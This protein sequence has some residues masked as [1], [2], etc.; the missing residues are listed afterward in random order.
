M[1]LWPR[2]CPWLAS[3]RGRAWTL[4]GIFGLGIALQLTTLFVVIEPDTL[5]WPDPKCHHA[6][7]ERLAAGQPFSDAET[8]LNL[9]YSP[10]Y[11]F[12]LSLMMRLVGPRVV[13]LRLFHIALFPVF[14]FCL[15]LLG[16]LWR[17]PRAGLVLAFTAAIY[18]PFLYIPLSLYP[19]ALLIYVYGAIGLTMY[20]LWRRMHLPGLA[21]LGAL[22]A[23]AVMVRPTSVVWIPVAVG[24]LLWR[25]GLRARRALA[26]AAILFLIPAAATLGW[27]ARNQAAHDQFTFSIT[28]AGTLL[29]TFNENQFG[30]AKLSTPP[31]R[32]LKR[33]RE[34]PSE[35]ERERIMA[36]EALRFVRE[37]PV[38]AAR[39]VALQC[40][41]TWH[42][43][44]QTHLK[45]GLATL[46]YKIPMAVPYLLLLTLGIIGIVI[47]RKDSLVRALVV[48]MVLNTLIN[49][50]FSVSV[51]YRV[52]TDFGF[53]L[54]A[55]LVVALAV[56]GKARVWGSGERTGSPVR[57]GRY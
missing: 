24:F 50:I 20:W 3:R 1:S 39:N 46:R 51:R 14:L 45:G 13:H 40:L 7:A 41:A 48:L 4:I 19:E 10:G 30:R 44:A 33:L 17:G 52:V 42:P 55:A 5:F 26:V 57:R 34:A 32:V 29:S 28:G 49:G 54:P 2:C 36:E 11:P 23:F 18:P 25:R 35:E 16:R 37:H 15:Y 27:M 31:E 38:W 22:I 47:E 21:L 56:W 6:I 9:K 53:M 43:I 8:I 12:A